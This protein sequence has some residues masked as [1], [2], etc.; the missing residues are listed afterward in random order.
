MNGC[1]IFK[2]LQEVYRP[3]LHNLNSK[4][5]SFLSLHTQHGIIVV[6]TEKKSPHTSLTHSNHPPERLQVGC[7]DRGHVSKSRRQFCNHQVELARGCGRCYG[8]SLPLLSLTCYILLFAARPAASRHPR[9]L[10]IPSPCAYATHV[11]LPARFRFSTRK[12][13]G[14]TATPD[15]WCQYE[16]R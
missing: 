13:T 9:G 7:P 2:P 14:W 11:L 5:A 12:G 8:E 3:E 1:M 6:I 10:R 16:V 15:L 4:H